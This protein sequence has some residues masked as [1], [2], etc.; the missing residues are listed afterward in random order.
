MGWIETCGREEEEMSWDFGKLETLCVY[1]YYVYVYPL[2]VCVS[3][4]C[5]CMCVCVCVCVC[6]RAHVCACM[7]MCVCAC[8][9]A[10]V[11]VCV[12]VCTIRMKQNIAVVLFYMKNINERLGYTHEKHCARSASPPLPPPPTSLIV[13]GFPFLRIFFLLDHPVASLSPVSDPG[14]RQNGKLPVG[15]AQSLIFH[16]K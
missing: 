15:V 3:C 16:S 8:A 2:C 6:V 5:M 7:C 1:V 14:E 11:R 9:C 4:V 12:S 13:Q 10:C